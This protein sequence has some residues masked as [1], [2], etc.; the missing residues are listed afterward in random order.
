MKA[1]KSKLDSK[2]L[3][4]IKELE[5]DGWN[6]DFLFSESP[7]PGKIPWITNFAEFFGQRDVANVSYFGVILLHKK[8]SCYAICFGKSH[9]YVRPHCDFDFGIELSK[10]I[11]DANDITQTSAR[12]FQGKQKKDIRS[13]GARARLNIPP[14]ESVDF[15]QAAII[16][17]KKESYGATGKFGVSALVSPPIQPSELGNF[18][19]SIEKELKRTERFKLPRTLLLK[20]KAEIARYDEQLLDELTAPVGLSDIATA[21]FD[22]FGVDFIFSS[23]GSFTLKCGHYKAKDLDQ[24]TMKEVKAYIKEKDIPR[25]KLLQLKIT[26]RREGEPEFTQSIKE[27][28]DFISDEDRVVLT[29]GKWL[30]FNQDYLDYLDASIRQIRVEE[31]E[32]DFLKIADIEGDFNAK[33]SESGYEVADRDFSIFRTSS[34]TAVEAWD[35]KKGGTVYAVKFGTAQKLNYVCDQAMNVLELMHNRANVQRIPDFDSYCLWFGYR[36]TKLPANLADS[37][38]IILKQKVDAWAR[39]CEELGIIPK[40]KMS[41]KIDPVHDSLA[42]VHAS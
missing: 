16:P 22:L 27:A 41:L 36:A 2:G 18:L 10:R 35:L 8:K 39:R 28:I 31:V 21:T 11:A 42:G 38:S 37:G 7:D 25:E 32:Q 6:G 3:T 14:G 17:A 24:L 5:L 15:L 30:Q 40:L 12:R 29:Q 33:L 4:S 1:L 23:Q 20:D 26:H 13:F 9:F 34:G 19:S